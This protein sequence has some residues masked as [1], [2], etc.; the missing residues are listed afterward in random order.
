MTAPIVGQKF[1]LES[2]N[3]HAHGTLGFAGTAFQTQVKHLLDS[4]VS[5]SRFAQPPRNCKPQHIGP[6]ASGMH[7][8]LRDHVGRAHGSIEFL[9]AYSEAAA[10]L[11]GAAHAAIFGIV[12]ECGRIAASGNRGR[13]EGSK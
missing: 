6:P 10:H 7:F 13:S 1:A 2:G 9:P 12:E 3:V 8:L 4:L 5:E 11:D